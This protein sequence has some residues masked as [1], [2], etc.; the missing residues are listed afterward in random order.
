MPGRSTAV[1]TSLLTVCLIYRTAAWILRT[2][3]TVESNLGTIG[4][5]LHIV[6]VAFVQVQNLVAIYTLEVEVHVETC[7]PE[8][9][10]EAVCELRHVVAADCTVFIQIQLAVSVNINESEVTYFCIVEV[11]ILF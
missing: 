2:L 10:A 4:V 9:T 8:L 1:V 11:R 3:P 7:I 5:T 6:E